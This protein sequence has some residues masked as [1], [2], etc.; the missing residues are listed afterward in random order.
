MGVVP[1]LV[2]LAIRALLASA[3][4]VDDNVSDWHDASCL[5]GCVESLQLLLR[6][7]GGLQVV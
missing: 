6:A 2:P 4:V 3:S 1:E 5:Q 7:I